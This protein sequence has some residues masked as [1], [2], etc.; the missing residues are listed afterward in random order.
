VAGIDNRVNGEFVKGL[1]S[2]FTL[3]F[4]QSKERI[5]YTDANGELRTTDWL[6]RPTD[7]RM[8]FAAVFQDELPSNPTF[9]V[10][11]NLLIGS[12]LPYYLGGNARYSQKP[13]TIPPYR[14]LD[15]GMSKIL[16]GAIGP[17]GYK[18]KHFKAIK[19]AW[20]SLEVF[21]LL[22]INNVIAYSWV[23]DLNNRVYGIPE[24]LTG[25]RLNLRLHA[26]F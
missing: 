4:L 5:T 7:R 9:R 23:N 20:I 22:G 19:E 26:S 10:N 13:G 3:S 15:L 25:R 14:R 18:G 6:R 17:R 8:N 24:Y 21:N 1:E 12:A 16:K 2:W 11:I